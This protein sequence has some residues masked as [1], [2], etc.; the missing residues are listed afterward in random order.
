MRLLKH[1]VSIRLFYFQCVDVALYLLENKVVSITC[2]GCEDGDHGD[3]PVLKQTSQGSVERTVASPQA[4]KGQDTLSAKLLDETAL[5]EDDTQDV[6][7]GRQSHKDGESSL[8]A[9]A[10]HVTEEGGSN[11]SLGLKNLCLGHTSKVGNVGQHVQNS[12]TANSQGSGDLEG[13]GRVLGLAEGVVCVAVA[14][15]TPNDVVQR[16]DYAVGTS[17]C[18]L[19]GVVEAVDLLDLLDI[20]QRSDDDDDDDANLDNTEDVLETNTPFQGRAVDQKRRRDAGHGNSSLVPIRNLDSGGIEDVLSKDDRVTSRPTQEDNISGVHARDEE[21][22][23]AVDV[24]EVVLLA[25]VLGETG[26]EFHV[27]GRAGPCDDTAGDP[28]E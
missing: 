2:G 18:A 24:F 20:G 11:E 12:D 14:N 6:A 17:S 7:K 16:G 15:E 10:K 22:R 5:R 13:A 9:L 1:E 8:G 19:E 23:L 25:T 27:D 4:R 26:A 28:Q 21:A 3:E